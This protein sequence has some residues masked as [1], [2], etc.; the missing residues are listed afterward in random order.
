MKP[1][2]TA[3]IDRLC[4]NCGLCCDSSLFA[5]VELRAGDDP[6]QL[7]KLG[8]TLVPK[9]KT[10]LAFAQP[11]TAFD[12]KL[13][14]IYHDRPKRC[15]LFECGMLIRVQSGDLS[16]ALALRTIAAAKRQVKSVRKLLRALGQRD[17][18]LA[19][20][21]R[22]TAAMSQPID[23]ANPAQAKCHGQLMTAANELMA[24]L[25]RDFLQ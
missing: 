1:N 2:L 18:Q 21:H 22:Y 3:S 12:G 15:R 17:E 20:T 24:R 25:Q 13:C 14:C 9:T 16:P 7:K 19:L 5:D 6:T 11:C 8:L 10:R 4:P 23:L